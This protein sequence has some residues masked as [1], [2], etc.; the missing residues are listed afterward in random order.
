MVHRSLGAEL[1]SDD[2][3]KCMKTILS[4]S[5]H[6]LPRY[7]KYCFLYLS[8]FPEGHLIECMRLIWLWIA[9]G[10]VEEKDGRTLK[11]VAEGYINQLINRSLIQVA[12]ITPYDKV[13][14]LRIHD[15]LRETILSK[16]KDQ[17][18]VAIAGE[19]NRRWPERVRRL[20]VHNSWENVQEN[21]NISQLR[22]VLMFGVVDLLSNS[23]KLSLFCG[24]LRLLKVLDL[25]GLPLEIFPEGIVQQFNLRYLSLRRT[26]IR[27]L[28]TSIGQLQN[29]ETLDLKHTFVTKL[30]VEILKLHR[31]RHLLAYHYNNSLEPYQAFHHLQGFKALEGIGRLPSLQKLNYL[32][33][34]EASGHLMREIGKLS[35]L[36]RLGVLKLRRQD[37]K[38]LFSSIKRLSNLRSLY[39]TSIREDEMIDLPYP[40][41]PPK[42]L[43]RLFLRGR[44]ES[45]PQWISSLHGLIKLF[46]KWSRLREDPLET[47]K[48]LPSL[49]Q[50]ELLQVYEGRTLCFKNGGFKFLNLE[51]MD[52]L[53]RVT[54]EKGAMPD[55]ETLIIQR[56]NGLKKMPTGI[57][58]LSKLKLLEFFDMPDDL[59]TTIQPDKQGDYAK[60]A[61]IPKVYSTYWRYGGWDACSLDRLS[62]RQR[63]EGPSTVIRG[64]SFRNWHKH[65]TT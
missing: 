34:S 51:K 46:L 55:L 57:E 65:G 17:Y 18:F 45:L 7:L 13:H 41:S 59:I 4:L 47:L 28:P 19:G 60:V 20:S 35:Q 54:V 15:L 14:L 23:S 26:K 29:L 21:S 64:S 32:E 31:L 5:Y 8:I 25:R 9:E 1:E 43:Q 36:R 33:A 63:R 38:V 53:E 40:Y 27:T 48:S 12:R 3:F 44:L 30:P 42:F 11:E 10:F 16:S 58:H 56:C 61:H 52:R 62:K 2:R 24:G 50:L 37:G 6:N 22:S 49:V 39:V